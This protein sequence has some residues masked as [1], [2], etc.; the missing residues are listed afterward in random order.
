[1]FFFAIGGLASPP[2]SIFVAANNAVASASALHAGKFSPSQ[3]VNL[4]YSE[5]D[6]EGHHQEN[7]TK[8][9]PL[10][11]EG[12]HLEQSELASPPQS[13]LFTANDAVASVSA[14]HAGKFSPSQYVNFDYSE[15]DHEGHHQ[16]NLTK[17]KPLPSEGD[18]LE[19]SELASPPQSIFV[20]AND[21]VASSSALHAGK[22]LPSQYVNFDCSDNDH[23][24]EGDHLER[25]EQVCVNP[26]DL[27]GSTACFGDGPDT[28]ERDNLTDQPMLRKSRSVSSLSST[29]EGGDVNPVSDSLGN[30]EEDTTI[31]V[32]T[33]PGLSESEEEFIRPK[34]SMQSSKALQYSRL[35][36][37]ERATLGGEEPPDSSDDEDYD[38]DIPTKS[39]DPLRNSSGD[40]DD[41]N[42]ESEL[43]AVGDDQPAQSMKLSLDSMA[44]YEGQ[45]AD[46]RKS[47]DGPTACIDEDE[48]M[49]GHESRKSPDGP[50]SHVEEDDSVSDEEP[51]KSPDGPSARVREDDQMME[52]ESKKLSDEE[53]DPL[54]D[55]ESKKSSDEEDGPLKDDE[56]DPMK[57]DESNKSSDEED[58]PMGESSETLQDSNLSVDLAAP[59]EPRRSSR[60]APMKKNPAVRIII[61]VPRKPSKNKRKPAFSKGEV[62]FR[63][64]VQLF[65]QTKIV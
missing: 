36:E 9:K 17:E 47:L 33:A 45:P 16:E 5:D 27:E 7:L 58:D 35:D 31:G 40:E 11:S 59:F 64:S 28:Q 30:G 60:I 65:Y 56:D 41:A 26:K 18:H 51:K 42:S 34:P 55:D 49:T 39:K 13:I 32:G 24:G 43:T 61:P 53:Y 37:E 21:A 19:E 38:P 10:P 15:D 22:F 25:S 23:E 52:D 62:S 44:V 63:V 50:A 48:P 29:S 4:D 2:Q 8:E 12:T 6:H 14:S 54:E 57:D 20:A 1:M 3:Y 46:F